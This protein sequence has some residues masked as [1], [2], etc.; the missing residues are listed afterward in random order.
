MVKDL[1]QSRD[2]STVGTGTFDITGTARV[3][4]GLSVGEGR[5]V[6]GGS[7]VGTQGAKVAVDRLND[8]SAF[9][10]LVSAL[11]TMV[12]IET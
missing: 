3:N 2:L 7:I 8:I 6:A 9:L 10:S 1:Q 12:V 5:V 4:L 11:D